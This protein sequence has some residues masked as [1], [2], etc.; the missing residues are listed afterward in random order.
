MGDNTHED[1]TAFHYRLT[2]LIIL[3]IKVITKSLEYFGNHTFL[4]L[5]ENEVYCI[6]YHCKAERIVT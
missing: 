5:F 1:I 6:V 2:K 4:E 3:L